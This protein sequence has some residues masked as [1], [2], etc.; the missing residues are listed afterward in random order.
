MKGLRRMI[1]RRK[2]TAGLR[3][4]FARTS[5]ALVLLAACAL[6]AAAQGGAS[7]DRSAAVR[8]LF[9]GTAVRKFAAAAFEE[10]VTSYQKSWPEAVIAGYRQKHLFDGL[11]PDETARMEGLIREFGDRVF[12]DI[13]ARVTGE[14]ITEDNLVALS[15]PAFARYLDDE[16]ISRLTEFTQTPL[17]RKFIGVSYEYLTEAMLSVMESK[18]VF[19][20]SADPDADSAKLD[21]LLKE[22]RAGGAFA[23]VQKEL[24]ARAP[25]FVAEFTPDE[26]RELAAF[27]QTP[28][29]AKVVRVYPPMLTDI[30]QRNAALYAPRAGAIAGEV[31]KEQMEFFIERTSVILKEAGPRMKEAARRRGN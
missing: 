25:K 13:K 20:V 24:A 8:K 2:G 1:R 5:A 27:W 11:T 31:L 28:L 16:E 21:R 22:E 9:E 3:A 7:P 15:A 18:G 6:P 12:R 4:P 29:G 23:D 19:Q 26:L 14:L 10:M 30:V 17:G